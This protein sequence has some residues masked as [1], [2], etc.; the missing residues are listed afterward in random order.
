[1]LNTFL[2]TGA[3]KLVRLGLDGNVVRELAVHLVL[4]TDPKRTCQ[5][6][7]ERHVRTFGFPIGSADEER[8]LL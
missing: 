7:P 3:I 1:M 5:E 6:C 4:E 2:S 8:Q